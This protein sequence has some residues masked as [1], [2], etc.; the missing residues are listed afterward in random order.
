MEMEAA[1]PPWRTLYGYIEN[2]KS[3]DIPALIA[4]GGN[5]FKPLRV[6]YPYTDWEKLCEQFQCNVKNGRRVV[7]VDFCDLI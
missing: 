7:F 6:E 2:A 4:A 1:S 5:I 3:E